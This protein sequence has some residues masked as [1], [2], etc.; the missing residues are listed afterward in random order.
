MLRRHPQ[1]PP[2]APFLEISRDA[3]PTAQVPV[4]QLAGSQWH[5]LGN[6]P[7]G[8]QI[9]APSLSSSRCWVCFSPTLA[10]VPS[11]YNGNNNSSYL[12][13]PQRESGEIVQATHLCWKRSSRQRDCQ[14]PLELV[15]GSRGSAPLPAPGMCSVIASASRSSPRGTAQG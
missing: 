6:R 14:S 12:L 2:P 4:P 9:Q 11:L 3:N 10:S 13:A 1:M 7:S 15:P 5:R 8:V